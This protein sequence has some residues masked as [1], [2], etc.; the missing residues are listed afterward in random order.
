MIHRCPESEVRRIFERYGKV[1][2]CIVNKDK[3]HAFVKMYYRKAAEIARN[4]M[5]ENRTPDL[6]LRVGRLLALYP[7]TLSLIL[8]AISSDPMG[9]RFRPSRLQRLPEWNQH[10]SNT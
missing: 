3:R 10:H 6:Q 4:A 2:T 8:T 9:C 1:Q 5:E 7:I